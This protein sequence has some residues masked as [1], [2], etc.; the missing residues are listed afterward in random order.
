MSN[1]NTTTCCA[2]TPNNDHAMSWL[3]FIL[4]AASVAIDAHDAIPLPG[5]C[6]EAPCV[7]P[8][9]IGQFSLGHGLWC[10]RHQRLASSRACLR[11]TQPITRK[12]TAPVSNSQE[13]PWFFGLLLFRFEPNRAIR[14]T[15]SKLTSQGSHL[16]GCTFRP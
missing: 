5:T 6:E 1:T 7:R 9:H 15:I 3:C 13:F 2:M 8:G 4:R 12:T 14:Y 16:Q 10:L 11:I